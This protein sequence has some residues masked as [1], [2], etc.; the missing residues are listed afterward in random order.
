MLQQQKKPKS[1]GS[2]PQNSPRKK[3]NTRYS[4]AKVQKLQDAIMQAMNSELD[5]TDSDSY[6]SA[7]QSQNDN[8]EE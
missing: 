3:Y 8:N 6:A 1:Q 7:S 2:S 5:S 4:K